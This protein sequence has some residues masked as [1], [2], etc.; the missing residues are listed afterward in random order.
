MTKHEAE[1]LLASMRV[2]IMALDV[3]ASLYGRLNARWAAVT[4][5]KIIQEMQRVAALIAKEYNL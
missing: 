5:M 2:E 1:G 4:T 3:M